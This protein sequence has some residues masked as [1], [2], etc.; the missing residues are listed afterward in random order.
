MLAKMG[1]KAYRMSIN[2][3]RIFPK[4]DEKE[5]NEKRL[6]FYDAVFDELRKYD[7]E[8]IVMLSHYEMPYHLI[9]KLLI[10]F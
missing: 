6:A 10:S 9:E 1:L 3:R 8:P 2:W 5:A 4:G 7:I